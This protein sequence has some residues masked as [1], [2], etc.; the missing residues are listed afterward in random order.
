[1]G[2]HFERSEIRN[3]MFAASIIASI[4]R[5]AQ[6]DRKQIVS[7]STADG[8]S[9]TRAARPLPGPTPLQLNLPL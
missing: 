3:S 6:L 5:C 4:F 7:G 1:M 8:Y 9:V 2:D